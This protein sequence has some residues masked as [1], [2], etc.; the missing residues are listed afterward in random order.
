[1]G[2]VLVADGAVVT[3]ESLAVS[4]PQATRARA[5]TISVCRR[6]RNGDLSRGGPGV[7]AP[8]W[9]HR[10]PALSDVVRLADAKRTSALRSVMKYEID[11]DHNG[12]WFIKDVWKRGGA[13]LSDPL[14][15]KGTAF[16]PEER[17]VFELD[18]LIPF[19][20]TN[21]ERQEERAYAHILEK[22]DK[23]LEQY[24]GMVSLQDR[25]ETL[26]Y[27]VLAQNIAALIPI[28]YTPTVGSAAVHF[29]RVFRRGRGLWITP[30][31]RGRVYEVLGHAR[32]DDIRLIVVTDNE[33][34]LGLGDQGAGGMVIPVGKLSLY[35]LGAGIHPAFTLPIS[36]DF[37]TDNQELLDDELY[38]GWRAPRLRGA[39]YDE[40]IEEFV[41]AVKR[42]WPEAVLQ[43]EDFKKVNAFHLLDRY[44]DVLPSFNDDIQGTGAVV[45]AGLL[46][47]CRATGV[48]IEDQRVMFVGAGAAGVGIA[49]QIRH[50]LEAA[51]VGDPLSQ[52]ALFDS[53]SLL[54]DDR[55]GLDE[56]KLEF[57]WAADSLEG[58]GIDD[59][60]R[61]DLAS[62]IA[63]F[64]PTVI[65]GTTGQAGV[66]DE[67]VI[68]TMG[69]HADRPLVMALSNPTSMTEGIPQD[70]IGWTEGRALI[71]TGSPFDPVLFDDREYPIS[72]CNNVYI[73]PGVGLGAIVSS[74]TKVNDAMFA[75]AAESLAD[76]LSDDD[77]AAGAL[78]PPITDLRPI[79]RVI[80]AA[81]ARAAR[82]TGVGADMTDAEIEAALDRQIWD[83]EYPRLL[84]I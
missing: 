67:A 64:E 10:L 16:T 11:R 71:A 62:F 70:I 81:V 13:V 3:D 51:G 78:Y 72:Q 35:S 33:R 55:E 8:S 50:L 4:V 34:I 40:L 32:C 43:W 23:P 38:V 80:A 14:L 29:S 84:P 9:R 20:Q 58:R 49:R 31:H 73:F 41:T 15:N 48:K 53:Q 17:E 12:H 27:Q 75:A 76:Q 25:N 52:L 42:R 36:L 83:L 82:D 69:E 54:V 21:R 57:S 47:A 56:H 39:E 63:A 19:Q 59:T 68:R 74:A 66:F 28:V 37:G 6:D 60:A 46:A 22:G 26:F 7:Y 1:M 45:A 18:G 5:E 79:S 65:I 2:V 24:I 77:L 44:Q 30:D 61:T